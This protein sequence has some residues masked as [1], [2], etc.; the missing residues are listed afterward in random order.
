MAQT[1]MSASK[2]LADSETVASAAASVAF[3]RMACMVVSLGQGDM[4]APLP[5]EKGREAPSAEVGAADER[6]VGMPTL[7]RPFKHS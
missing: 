1:L 3:F 5:K 4:K 6:M 2:A 7:R